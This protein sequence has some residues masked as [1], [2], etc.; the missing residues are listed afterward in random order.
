MSTLEALNKFID[1]IEATGGVMNIA[2]DDSPYLVPVADEEWADLADA[3]LA[4]CKALDRSPK[5]EEQPNPFAIQPKSQKRQEEKPADTSN[6]A[7]ITTAPDLLEAC[8]L[9][10]PLTHYDS[11]EGLNFHPVEREAH[12]TCGAAKAR[13]AIAKAKGQEEK[14]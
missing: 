8:E 2:E 11:C 10:C 4:A 3:Y 7:L 5:I 6:A 12:C 1:T 13:S 9:L 14:P